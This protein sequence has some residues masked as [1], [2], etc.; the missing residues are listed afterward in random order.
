[1]LNGYKLEQR[2]S[3]LQEE[4]NTQINLMVSKAKHEGKP[5]PMM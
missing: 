1:M 4:E 2:L 3:K 5:F